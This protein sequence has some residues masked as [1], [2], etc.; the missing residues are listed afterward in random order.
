MQLLRLEGIML[1]FPARK[2]PALEPGGHCNTSDTWNRAAKGLAHIA[3]C[4][5][6]A[7]SR[8]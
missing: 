4:T 3:G 1:M 8:R 6:S 7:V 5:C 2:M